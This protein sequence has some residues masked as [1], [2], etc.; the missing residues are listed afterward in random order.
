VEFCTLLGPSR[1][2]QDDDPADD[3]GLEEPDTGRV[4]LGGKGRHRTAPLR[5]LG[6][7]RL[8]GLRALPAYERRDK[9]RLRPAS[10]GSRPRRASQRASQ[11]LAT[12]RLAGY[13]ARKPN[14]LSGGQQ[15]RVAQARAVS[16]SARA[17]LDEPSGPST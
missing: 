5:P 7:H 3:R 16:T 1:V 2:G 14:Q 10:Q 6:Q 11:A 4:E 15:Q 8:P 17:L 13:E 12:V 9:R